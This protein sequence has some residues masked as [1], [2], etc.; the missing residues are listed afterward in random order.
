[1]KRLIQVGRDE[2]LERIVATVLPENTGMRVLAA[3]SGFKQIKNEDLSSISLALDLR[4]AT[5]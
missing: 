4:E 2:Q 1:M 5:V 3:R